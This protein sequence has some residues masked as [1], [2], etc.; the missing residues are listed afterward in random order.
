MRATPANTR[1][2]SPARSPYTKSLALVTA[3]GGGSDYCNIS[4]WDT[5]TNH[6]FIACYNQGGNGYAASQFDAAIPVGQLKVTLEQ[7]PNYSYAQK[8]QTC[9]FQKLNLPDSR[10]KIESDHDRA[11]CRASSKSCWYTSGGAFSLENG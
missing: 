10:W 3:Y 6:I 5:A 11:R 8:M 7:V 2:R 4:S 1:S 9:A